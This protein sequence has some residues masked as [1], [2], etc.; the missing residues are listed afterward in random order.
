MNARAQLAESGKPQTTWWDAGDP[1]RGPP[2]LTLCPA[3]FPEAQASPVQTGGS[4]VR[5]C[6]GFC[7]HPAPG[8]VLVDVVGSSGLCEGEGLPSSRPGSSGG[9]ANLGLSACL[10]GKGWLRSS[11]LMGMGSWCARPLLSLSD[12]WL[13]SRGGRAGSG[14]LP[15]GG[16]PA[17]WRGLEEGAGEEG[18]GK[19]GPGLAPPRS[20]VPSPSLGT[21]SQRGW[22]LLPV[23]AGRVGDGRGRLSHSPAGRCVQAGPPGRLPADPARLSSSRD[24]G[25]DTPRAGGLWADVAHVGS[26]H[27]TLTHK[28]TTVRRG[29]ET[30]YHVTRG[31][32]SWVNLGSGGRE[33][34]GVPSVYLEAPLQPVGYVPSSSCE[35]AWGSSGDSR[36][37][38]AHLAPQPSPL[39]PSRTCHREAHFPGSTPWD[40]IASS[41]VAPEDRA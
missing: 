35:A 30:G 14:G 6:P 4:W 26:S 21:R 32:G 9:L 39:R 8:M 34:G 19:E 23:S 33:A 22:K 38:A 41:L 13:C 15:G 37:V 3:L 31:A 20:L 5:Q 36:G 10:S 16:G 11:G 7:P 29:V 28:G 25:S 18:L 1:R 12:P 2:A 27:H 40:V 24:L 17:L